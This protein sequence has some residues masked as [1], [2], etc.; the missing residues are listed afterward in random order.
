VTLPS[1]LSAG[2]LPVLLAGLAAAVLAGLPAPSRLDGLV[3]RPAVP[4]R[5]PVGLAPLAGPIVAGLLLGPVGALLGVL[6]AGFGR[7]AWVSRQA[8]RARDRER[9]GAVEA[10]AVLGSELRAGRPAAEALEVAAEVAVGPFAATLAA[11]AT[12]AR[13]GVE[14]ARV[15]QRSAA[16]SAVPELVRGLGACWQVC[17]QTGSSLAAAVDRLDEALRAEREQRLA[18]ESELAGPRATAGLLAVLPLAGI[19]LASGLG[20]HPLQV[21]LHTTIGLTCLAV[22]LAL[23]ALGVWWTGRM[24][25]AAGGAR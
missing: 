19:A 16:T 17:S 14:P 9:D 18:V 8:A 12:G 6:A 3:P 5:S 1:E 11:A 23:D 24:V 21:L 15:F 20:A 25:A 22:G 10:L 7:R 4:R 2:L 13:F